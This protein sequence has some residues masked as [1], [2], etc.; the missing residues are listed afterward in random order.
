VVTAIT[1][2]VVL[3]SDGNVYKGRTSQEMK[4]LSNIFNSET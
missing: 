3:F 1:I 2:H 4:H